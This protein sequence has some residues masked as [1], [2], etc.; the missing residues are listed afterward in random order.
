MINSETLLARA[1]TNILHVQDYLSYRK[2][3]SVQLRDADPSQG[4]QG[5]MQSIQNMTLH[6]P[7]FSLFKGE[8]QKREIIPFDEE[9]TLYSLAHTC[10]QKFWVWMHTI[11]L[12]KGH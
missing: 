2:L 7:L 3:K 12:W 10:V 6:Y 8:L 1:H 4:H 5:L 11:L 9:K